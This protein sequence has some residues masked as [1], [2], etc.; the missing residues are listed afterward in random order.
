[1]AQPL[2]TSNC[3]KPSPSLGSASPGHRKGL[4]LGNPGSVQR[5]ES[6]LAP[7]CLRTGLFLEYLVIFY[8]SFLVG[9]GEG[10]GSI[11]VQG[12]EGTVR[13]R[14]PLPGEEG[15]G[16]RERKP[17]NCL[18][19]G[20]EENSAEVLG[21]DSQ[22]KEVRGTQV[23]VISA[24]PCSGPLCPQDI[25]RK[26]SAVSSPFPFPEVDHLPLPPFLSSLS[27][28]SPPVPHHHIL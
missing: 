13:N 17:A 27:A 28:L 2:P 12:N 16:S 23:G 25:P 14:N 1:M 24:H 20:L 6:P 11:V 4:L 7:P 21:V 22:G 26:E 18:G 3:P 9:H 10:R 8:F 5:R 19:S 15:A